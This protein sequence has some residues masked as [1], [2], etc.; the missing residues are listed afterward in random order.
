MN[1]PAV[2]KEET[3]CSVDYTV[4]ILHTRPEISENAEFLL[5]YRAK[6]SRG[7][8][9]VSEMFC[10]AFKTAHPAWIIKKVIVKEQA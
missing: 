4:W 9:F 5:S 3:D 2:E 7:K 10:E 8:Q 6:E 1:N